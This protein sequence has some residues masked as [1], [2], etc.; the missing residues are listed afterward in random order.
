MVLM[1]AAR[2]SHAKGSSS[3]DG[4]LVLHVGGILDMIARPKV[5]ASTACNVEFMRSTCCRF[6]SSDSR[7]FGVHQLIARRAAYPDTLHA[8]SAFSGN[9][10]IP[11]SCGI[12]RARP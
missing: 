2:I 10:E 11:E 3:P 4:S 7:C 12:A 5:V 6:P 8:T 1:S 9:V